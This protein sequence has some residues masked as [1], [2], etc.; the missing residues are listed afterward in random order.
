MKKELFHLPVLHQEVLE[1]LCQKDIQTFFDGTLGLGGHAELILN[2]FPTLQHYV[3]TELDLEHLAYAQ[4]RL[5]AFATKINIHNTNFSNIATILQ[6][7]PSKK[8]LAVLLDL[9]LCSNQVDQAEKGFSFH[10][11]GPLK[12][13]FSGENSA[14]V[15]LNEASTEHLSRVFKEYGELSQHKRIA[16]RIAFARKQVPLKTTRQLREIIE[17]ATHPREHKRNVLLGFQAIR[18]EVNDE[19]NV[20]KQAITGAFDIMQPGDRL[21]IMSYHS[22]EDRLV[23]HMFKEASTPVTTADSFSF[24]SIVKEAH[25]WLHTKKPILPSDKEIAENPRA[26]SVR[27]RIIER[28]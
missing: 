16:Q 1:Q 24:H 2:H 22:L 26:R 13:S 28:K 9:G 14:E 19:L 17:K 4:K 11:D 18:M 7:S 20:V 6:E 12:M 27:F 23:K 15:F 10:G 21:G 5:N 3:A 8:P 25:F